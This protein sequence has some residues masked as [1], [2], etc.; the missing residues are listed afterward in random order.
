MPR[1]KRSVGWQGAPLEL[2]P[3][4]KPRIAPLREGF[5]LPGYGAPAPPTSL[6]DPSGD[7]DRTDGEAVPYRR[8]SMRL[9]MAAASNPLECQ[10]VLV[11]GALADT[12]RGP[13]ASRRKLWAQL[14][15]RCGFEDPFLLS[16][17]LIYSVMG[18]LKQGGYRSASQYLESA[19]GAHVALGHPWNAQLQQARR[20]AIRSCKRF[21]GNAKQAGGLPLTR[22][23]EVVSQ[24]PLARGGPLWPGRSTM[25]ASWW[26]LREREAAQA[27]RK[28][29]Q[30]DESAKTISWRLPSS[31]TDQAALG[32]VRTHACACSIGNVHTCPFHLMLQQLQAIHTDPSTPVFPSATGDPATKIGW[33]DTFEAIAVRLGLPIL[34]PNGARVF[35][36][37]SARVTGAR[38]LASTNIELWRIQLFGRWG[39]AVFLHYIQDAPNIQ[40]QTLALESSAMLSIQT[41]KAQLEALVRQVQ[42]KQEPLALVQQE[43]LTDCQA[44][45]EDNPPTEIS[46]SEPWVLNTNPS[47]KLH[48]ALICAKEVNPRSWRTRCGW[49]FA[50]RAADYTMY[51]SDLGGPLNAVKCRK[52]FPEQCEEAP[53]G[54]SS[55][56]SSTTSSDDSA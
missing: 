41:A 30:V 50:V 8:G 48:R 16:P 2:V 43:N 56:E 12:T 10:R 13:D 55:S 23:P 9:A 22:L 53:K 46:G 4:A 3:V 27:K 5:A 14:A 39:S 6:S 18:A 32:A 33:A 25:L 26:L 29:I 40:M 1:F 52:C 45:L 24:E 21:L 54:S 49:N 42:T 20:A 17:Q 37:H 7:R 35:T 47:G 44:V 28:H 34:Y 11:A 36:G 31:K 15:R 38:H 19:Q 51:D